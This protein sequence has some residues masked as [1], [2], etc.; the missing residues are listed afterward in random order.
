MCGQYF[1]PFSFFAAAVLNHC[2]SKNLHIATA[3]KK[4]LLLEQQLYSI[5][6]HVCRSL[7][8]DCTVSIQLPLSLFGPCV[9]PDH[10]Q[11]TLLS[12]APLGYFHYSHGNRLLVACELTSIHCLPRVVFVLGSPQNCHLAPSS[13]DQVWLLKMGQVGCLVIK[14]L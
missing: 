9:S 6:V 3:I 11:P 14:T 13:T 2:I 8:Y 7:S 10:P 12:K 4:H 5:G 1:P